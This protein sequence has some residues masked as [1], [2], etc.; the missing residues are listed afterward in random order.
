MRALR[1]SLP[2]VLVSTAIALLLLAAMWLSS[3]W[4]YDSHKTRDALEWRH[5]VLNGETPY[6]WDFERRSDV[7][8]GNGL[9]TFSWSGGVLS[10]SAM[11]INALSLAPLTVLPARAG[12]GSAMSSSLALT[13][14]TVMP[15]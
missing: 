14:S 8:S 6:R 4:L 9:E 3:L 7:T 15:G 10:G 1:L 13:R 2:R 12:M 5:A 11:D